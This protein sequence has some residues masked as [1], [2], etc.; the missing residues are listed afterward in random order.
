MA[1][2]NIDLPDHVIKILEHEAID[3]KSKFK[4][5]VETALEMMAGYSKYN[6]KGELF[7][8]TE[9]H[10][11]LFKTIVDDHYKNQKTK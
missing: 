3:S 8:F 2:K 9:Q 4:N 1:R 5:W 11:Q 6:E 7:G 10:M